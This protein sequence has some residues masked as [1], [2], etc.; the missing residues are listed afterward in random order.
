MALNINLRR[1]NLLFQ[2]GL[3]IDIQDNCVSIAY[4]KGS[5]KGVK[6]AAHAIH[7]LEKDGTVEE[8]LGIEVY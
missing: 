3:G 6:L 1:L 2:T 7:P 5:F 8:K 4:L